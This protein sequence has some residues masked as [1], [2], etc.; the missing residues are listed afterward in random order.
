MGPEILREMGPFSDPPP[1]P[2]YSVLKDDEN[3]ETEINTNFTNQ[4]V[5]HFE[6]S[7]FL[8]ILTSFYEQRQVHSVLP[9][10]PDMNGDRLTEKAKRPC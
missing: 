8:S 1:P 3:F 2:K 9:V 6:S 4:D 10:S 5:T 7:L